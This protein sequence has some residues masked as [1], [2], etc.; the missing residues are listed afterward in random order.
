MEKTG[1]LGRRLT[2]DLP[3]EQIDD[4]VSGRLA[5]LRGQVRLKGFRPGKV[6]LNVIRQRYGA[7]IRQEVM[8]EAM[9]GALQEAI[10]DQE[11]RIA[12]VSSISPQEDAAEVEGSFRFIAEVEIFPEIPEIDASGIE[13]ER[14]VVEVGEADVD[15]MIQTLR[16]QRRSWSDAGRPAAEG[17]RVS[18]EF[19]ARDG[20]TRIPES[21]ESKLQ[22]VLGSGALFEA[23]DQALTGLAAGDEKTLEL[24]FPEDFGNPDLADRKLE[25]SLVVNAVQASDMPE[26][27]DEFAR[28]FGVDGGLDQLRSDVRRNLEREMRGARVNRLKKR[29]T[30]ALA[31]RYADFSL[32]ESAVRQELQQMQAQL[33]QQYGEQVNLPEDQLRP[34]AERRVRLGFLLAE[35]ARQQEMNV[36]PDRVQAHIAEIAETYDNPQEVVELYRQNPQMMGQIENSVLEEQVVDW[37]LE[38]A[39]V[40]DREMSFKELMDSV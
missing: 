30:D 21:G 29:V 22:P 28:S 6:P 11:L 7:Q 27:D 14:P 17:D 5:E 37:V 19:H 35:I 3:A 13:I 34:G 12:G 23:F 32:P 25:V 16:E 24:E 9:Q 31:E 33:K 2:V 10:E 15:D 1:D 20:D 40:T 38:H 26:A 8:Q 18:I 4:K 36:D 39:S